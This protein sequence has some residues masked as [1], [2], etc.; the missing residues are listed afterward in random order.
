VV[1]KPTVAVRPVYAAAGGNIAVAQGGTGMTFILGHEGCRIR[2]TIAKPGE[3]LAQSD[4]TRDIA[5]GAEPPL[6]EQRFYEPSPACIAAT[7]RVRAFWGQVEV[8]DDSLLSPVQH[9]WNN[10][11]PAPGTDSHRL[12][13]AGCEIEI[14]TSKA[15]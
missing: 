1:R 12:G 7:L 15:E 9:R 8:I 6:L 2:V 4:A 3:K 13:G 11:R 10:P 5:H 14:Q